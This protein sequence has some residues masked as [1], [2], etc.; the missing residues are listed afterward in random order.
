MA[1]QSNDV[2]TGIRLVNFPTQPTA[3]RLEVG[4]GR[5]NGWICGGQVRR[6]RKNE[7]E[8]AIEGTK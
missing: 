3:K 7:S 5:D 2:G 1:A 4:I 8:G 6:I